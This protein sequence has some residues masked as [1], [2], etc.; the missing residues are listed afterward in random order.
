MKC[1]WRRKS[2]PFFSSDFWWK[3]GF[4]TASTS[5]L[6]DAAQL[7]R[8]A[9]LG[10]QCWASRRHTQV[11]GLP[12]TGTIPGGQVKV[13]DWFFFD[14]RSSFAMTATT[15][16]AMPPT[17]HQLTSAGGSEETDESSCLRTHSCNVCGTHPIFGAIDSIADHS[18]G[19]SP[20]CSCT[21]R[22]AHSRVSGEKRFDFFMAPSSQIKEPPQNPGRFSKAAVSIQPG[23]QR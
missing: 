3:L 5:K 22:T 11:P 10:A 15:P 20:R 13:E 1:K 2:T 14:L 17:S 4:S 8:A 6:G 9:S 16:A 19:Y 23:C 18:D 21:R 7:H 12:G